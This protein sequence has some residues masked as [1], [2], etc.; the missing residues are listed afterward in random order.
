M[1]VLL[2][3]QHGGFT[4]TTTIAVSGVYR[5]MLADLNGDG[6]LDAVVQTSLNAATYL[7]DGK[8]DLTA[9]QSGIPYPGADTLPAQIGDVN[10]DGIPDLI[11]PAD[12]SIG[13]ALG[14]GNGKVTMAPYAVGVGQAPGQIFL[15]NPHGQSAASGKPDLVAPDS[16]VGVTVLINLTK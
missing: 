1:Y 2:N 4:Q 7:G 15:E 8:G 5:V 10:G 3:N 14:L 6:N 11:L 12:G 13:I 9:G 16:S